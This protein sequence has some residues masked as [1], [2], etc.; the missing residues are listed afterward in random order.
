MKATILTSTL[1]ALSLAAALAAPA[2]AARPDGLHAGDA[3]GV[4]I[5]HRAG[6]DHGWHLETTDPRKSGAHT[7]TGTITTDGKFSDV[8]LVRAEKDDSATIDGNG[9]LNFSFVTYDG[10]DG[11][12][13]RDAG[14]NELTFTLYLDGSL[15]STSQ[16]NLGDNS[17]H[18]AGNPF[19]LHEADYNGRPDGFHSGD[20]SGI[21]LWH[22]TGV[23]HGWHLETTDPAKTGAHNYTGTV[24]TDG[25]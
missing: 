19:T 15:L 2:L 16:I 23:D 4:Y 10:I 21:Y 3:A 7:Y 13:F 5:W 25:K 18:P 17:H 9:N 20:S 11:V 6:V 22:R 12:D 1:A 8:Q 24:T 14:G